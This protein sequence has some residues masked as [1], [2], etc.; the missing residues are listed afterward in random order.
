MTTDLSCLGASRSYS[1][2]DVRHQCVHVNS[3]GG[4]NKPRRPQPRQR[5][6]WPSESGQDYRLRV[7]AVTQSVPVQGI[8]CTSDEQRAPLR[9]YRH[10]R[11]VF[12]P[13]DS[14]SSSRPFRTSSVTI[15][16]HSRCVPMARP[17]NPASAPS[18]ALCLSLSLL[19]PLSLLAHIPVA[20]SAY[21]DYIPFSF[22]VRYS[23]YASRTPF[24]FP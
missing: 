5:S 4:P 23:S 1:P 8:H 19:L 14:R 22:Y 18:L 3:S 2:Q 7:C 24:P 16:S 11:R 20:P 6:C 9:V 21:L 17:S 13:P 12:R 10:V 15:R